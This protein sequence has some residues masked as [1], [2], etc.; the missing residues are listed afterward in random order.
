MSWAIVVTVFLIVG[1]RAHVA[2]EKAK[3]R[4][5]TELLLQKYR[6]NGPAPVEWGGKEAA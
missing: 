1:W 4:M 2:G 6:V 3:R 5:K